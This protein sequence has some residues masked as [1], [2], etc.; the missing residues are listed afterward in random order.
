MAKLKV[1]AETSNER[2]IV[3]GRLPILET[4][5]NFKNPDMRRVLDDPEDA[6]HLQWLTEDQLVAV[7]DA[8]DK[9]PRGTEE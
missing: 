9:R 4:G 5:E 8:I 1:L 7:I 3:V 6:V 2:V